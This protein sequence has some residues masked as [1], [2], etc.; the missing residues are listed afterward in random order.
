MFIIESRKTYHGIFR[1]DSQ[2]WAEE[3]IINNHGPLCAIYPP[4]A[5]AGPGVIEGDSPAFMHLISANRGINDPEDPSQP[6]WGGQYKR[7]EGTNHWV[8]GPGGSTISKWKDYFQSEF[9]ERAD[10]CVE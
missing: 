6:S 2:E 8:D 1:S 5:I 9:K 3:N 10:W 4:K 7:K